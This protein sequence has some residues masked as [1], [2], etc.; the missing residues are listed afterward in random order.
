MGLVNPLWLVFVE[1]TSI[2]HRHNCICSQGVPKPKTTRK[3]SR[4]APNLHV[5]NRKYSVPGEF[6][7]ADLNLDSSGSVT[8]EED[9]ANK[10]EENL[11]LNQRQSLET[12]LT[13]GWTSL[14][15]LDNEIDAESN[16]GKASPASSWVLECKQLVQSKSTGKVPDPFQRLVISL[17]VSTAR[18]LLGSYE[19]EEQLCGTCFLKREGYIGKD[20]I[21]GEDQYVPPPDTWFVDEGDNYY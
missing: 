12:P 17:Y 16:Q 18:N 6:D 5:K 4:K 3:P 14:G 1:C 13:E 19:L 10:Y 20:G 9:I 7:L 21:D 2:E 8:P 11:P 15:G